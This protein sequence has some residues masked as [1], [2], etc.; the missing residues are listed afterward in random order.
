MLSHI[1]LPPVETELQQI[2]RK[3]FGILSHAISTSGISLAIYWIL[4]LKQTVELINVSH[5]KA[6]HGHVLCVQ[7]FSYTL[8]NATLQE[9]KD[10]YS[11]QKL[12]NMT[13]QIRASY[14]GAF[15]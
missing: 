7:G 4:C 5:R 9:L 6:G 15:T 10:F 13:G 8:A 11:K 3:E 1:I 2:R 14:L 12:Y